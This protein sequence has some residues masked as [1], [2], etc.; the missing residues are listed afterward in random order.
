MQEKWEFKLDNAEVLEKNQLY[1]VLTRTLETGT[2]E[3]GIFLSYYYRS[4]GAV[5]ENVRLKPNTKL[6]ESSGKFKVSFDLVHFNA[7]LNIH[8]EG[9]E[10]ME[11]SYSFIP[12]EQRLVLTG[13]YW[14]ERE[15]DDI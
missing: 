7:C 8:D 4:E 10:E 5:V 6:D 12:D 13:P 9:K 15:P 3:L 2:K 11:L 1:D 14:P